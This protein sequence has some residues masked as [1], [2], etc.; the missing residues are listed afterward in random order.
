MRSQRLT[1]LR[2]PVRIIASGRWPAFAQRET[3]GPF[4]KTR[5]QE[6]CCRGEEITP[7]NLLGAS[8]A[9]KLP[10]SYSLQ[11][12]SLGTRPPWEWE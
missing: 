11:V 8:E 2:P 3:L 7:S 12:A 9:P 10:T 4:T 1:R 6:G 5:L